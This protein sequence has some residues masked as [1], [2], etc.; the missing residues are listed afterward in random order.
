MTSCKKDWNHRNFGEIYDKPQ[1]E[2]VNKDMFLTITDEDI[3]VIVKMLKD[4]AKTLP[5]ADSSA[6]VRT[7][8]SI[9]FSQQ[10]ADIYS[11]RP[12]LEK[13]LAVKYAPKAGSVSA[14]V[15]SEIIVEYRVMV[16]ESAPALNPYELDSADYLAMGNTYGYPGYYYNFD[17]GMDKTFFLTT[18]LAQKYPYA[19]V[20]DVVALSYKFFFSTALGSGLFSEIFV[21]TSNGWEVQH[22][23]DKF[24][25]Q[26]DR[27]W[28]YVKNTMIHAISFLTGTF[29][30]WT[31]V[32][33]DGGAKTWYLS[34]S[35]GAVCSGYNSGVDEDDWLV[36]PKFNFSDREF[37]RIN[38]QAAHNYWVTNNECELYVSTTYNTGAGINEADWTKIEEYDYKLSKDWTFHDYSISLTPFVGNS[39]VHIAYR[40][41]TWLSTGGAA[42][43][44]V[45]NL[46]I[47]EKEVGQE[48]E[49]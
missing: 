27:S 29:G 47:E 32:N 48:D 9:S 28:K 31:T 33:V 34:S 37:A 4:E 16:D 30:A 6:L 38:F 19:Q 13:Y 8:D 21:K 44:E 35:Y 15:G 25:L 17:K 23:Q 24:I 39:N 40:Y 12:Y 20:G 7:A 18:F 26:S 45:K 22:R 41:R 36:S 2:A 1:T 46:V 3:P 42:Q 14:V 5:T 10:F 49:Q 11:A 43:M